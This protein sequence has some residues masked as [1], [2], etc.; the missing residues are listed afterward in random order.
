[1]NKETHDALLA[2]SQMV[3]EHDGHELVIDI[4]AKFNVLLESL[5]MV[6][7]CERCDDY[8]VRWPDRFHKGWAFYS[9]YKCGFEYQC[10]WAA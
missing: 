4:L 2:V 7:H 9:C 6:D 5:A 8:E 1:M 3:I 10:G